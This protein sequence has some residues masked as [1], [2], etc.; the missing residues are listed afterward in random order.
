MLL[1]ALVVVVV[2]VVVSAAAVLVTRLTMKGTRSEHRARVLSGATEVI[3]TV[4]GRE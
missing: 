4:R 3:R 2:T 1:G